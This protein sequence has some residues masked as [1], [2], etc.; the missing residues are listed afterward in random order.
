M[1]GSH[2]SYAR[3]AIPGL[4]ALSL[5]ACQASDASGLAQVV[6]SFSGALPGDAGGIV[7]SAG[8]MVGTLAANQRQAEAE[9]RAREAEQ[10]RLAR[11]AELSRTT[12]GRRILAR[13]DAAE[14]KKQEEQQ[15]L[16]VEITQALTRSTIEDN[17]SAEQDWDD[18]YRQTCSPGSG[19]FC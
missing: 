11:R 17:S 15:R 3:L 9:Q 14:Q 6:Q 8:G 18:K 10:Q 19:N 13:E 1:R 2:S 4:L 16:M 5:A 12:E 7:R